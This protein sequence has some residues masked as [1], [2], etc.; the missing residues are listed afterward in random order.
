[1]IASDTISLK[2]LTTAGLFK[3]CRGRLLPVGHDRI[4]AA[5]PGACDATRATPEDRDGTMVS[6]QQ[7][8]GAP[9]RDGPGSGLE[10]QSS[11]CSFFAEHVGVEGKDA[12]DSDAAGRSAC[13][14]VGQ[15]GADDLE[16]GIEIDPV[17]GE[18]MFLALVIDP[19]GGEAGISAE[20]L[21]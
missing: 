15:Q 2:K 8:R 21:E 6:G 16:M 11:A 12:L 17:D 9:Q 1:M 4:R 13:R 18:D 14:E 20:R 10:N 3:D 7:K 19:G 5:T